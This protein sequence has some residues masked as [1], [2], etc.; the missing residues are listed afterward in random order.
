MNNKILVI[1]DDSAI[2]DLLSMLLNMHDF[3]VITAN[4]GT[5]GIELVRTQ[6]PSVVILDLMMP[7]PNGWAVSKA[8]R[9]FSNVP[10][11]ILSAINDPSMVASV[12]DAGADDFLVKPVPSGTLVAH[13]K[14]LMRRSDISKKN[15][16]LP[17]STQPNHI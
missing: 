6:S 12:L 10:I 17:V 4:S 16:S 11:M 3:N 8:I 5:E 7:D 13:I 9:E 15:A 14:K 2:T 1:D